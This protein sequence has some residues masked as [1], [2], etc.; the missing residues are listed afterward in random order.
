LNS[1]KN[2]CNNKLNLF[3]DA[4]VNPK[5]HMG[6]GAYLLISEHEFFQEALKNQVKLKRFENT[7]STKLELQTLLWALNDI[8]KVDNKLNIYTD[9]QNI[10][11]LNERRQRLEKNNY[12]SKK[13]ARI[14]NYKLYQ[15]FYKI[16]D[17]LDYKIIKVCGH[18]AKANKTEID[19]LF[20]L[21][22][23]TSRNALRDDK[24]KSLEVR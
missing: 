22:D 8:Q 9:C 1:I 12:R 14:N 19:I 24:R 23:R 4:S 13:N 5:L 11:S 10:L 15:E 6:Y 7:S 2:P 18:K 3:T 21:V 20:A 16:T 17:Q